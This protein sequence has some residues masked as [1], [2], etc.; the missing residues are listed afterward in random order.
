[1]L[2]RHFCKHFIT[3]TIISRTS[4]KTLYN[5]LSDTHITNWGL[6][7]FTFF[8]QGMVYVGGGR[9]ML[10]REVDVGRGRFILG[11]D[12]HLFQTRFVI[13]WENNRDGNIA[14]PLSLKTIGSAGYKDKWNKKFGCM[15]VNRMLEGGRFMLEG[16]V[17]LRGEGTAKESL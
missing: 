12:L 1:M 4:C 17:H 14:M 6:R 7:R 10:E 16:R 3:E 15:Q 9:F 8:G 2:T 13:S 11:A 5:V